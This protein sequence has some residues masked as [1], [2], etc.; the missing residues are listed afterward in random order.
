MLAYAVV[1]ENCGDKNVSIPEVS[2]RLLA[3]L[4]ENL[5]VGISQLKP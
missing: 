4:I 2:I 1:A 5:G 3:K